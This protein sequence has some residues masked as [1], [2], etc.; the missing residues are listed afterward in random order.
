MRVLM[1][2]EMPVEAANNAIK[3]G[4]MARTVQSIVDDLKPEATYFLTL[5]GKR[6]GLLILDLADPSQIPA[7]ADPWFLAFNASVEIHPVMV[8]ADLSRAGLDIERMAR[9]YG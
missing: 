5:N 3:E 7:M 9:K 4:T 2:V 8:P 6:T 1:K